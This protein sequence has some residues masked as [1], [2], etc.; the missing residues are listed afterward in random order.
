VGQ[1]W[2]LNQLAG[3]EASERR[4][5]KGDHDWHSD[6]ETGELKGG[7]FLLRTTPSAVE[8]KLRV[9]VVPLTGLPTTTNCSH[10]CVV[11]TAITLN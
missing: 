6:T 3:V 1:E 11:Q 9:P 2:V 4:Y 10:G 7:P 8:Q 5:C